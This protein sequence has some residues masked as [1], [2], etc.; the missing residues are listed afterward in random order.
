MRTTLIL[1]DDVLRA[2][3][4]LAEEK[5]VTLGEAVSELLRGALRPDL[6]QREE[7]GY[8]VFDVSPDAHLLALARGRGVRLATFGRD[9][10]E[11]L[12][13]DMDPEEA[14]TLIP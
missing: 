2:A 8:P 3:R 7:G 13:A 12:P 1:V 4:A 10:A 9:P 11:L 5:D 6:L 14:L